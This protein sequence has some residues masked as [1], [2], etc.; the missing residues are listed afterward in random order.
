MPVSRLS[1]LCA[2][3][4]LAIPACSLLWDDDDAGAGSTTSLGN[5]EWVL[6]RIFL[7]GV[8]LDA[9]N[10]DVPATIRFAPP[11]RSRARSSE[12]TGAM[13]G[14]T[15]CNDFSGEYAAA[16]T[17]GSQGTLELSNLIHT[18]KA[19][20]GNVAQIDGAFL[21]GLR[22]AYTYERDSATLRIQVAPDAPAPAISLVF[23]R[24]R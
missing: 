21:A 8:V 24:I 18:E 9:T 7:S 10:L 23:V 5:T 14:Y 20:S 19:C 15:G 22:D 11:R 1:L 17:N 12:E 2:L 16:A 3:I 4:V 6:Q 13:D